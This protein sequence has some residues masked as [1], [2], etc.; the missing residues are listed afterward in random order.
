MIQTLPLLRKCFGCAFFQ[1]GSVNDLPIYVGDYY[2]SLFVEGAG[3]AITA[4]LDKTANIKFLDCKVFVRLD[5][6]IPDLTSRTNVGT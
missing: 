4:I 1:V 3:K 6:Y 2:S 5:P